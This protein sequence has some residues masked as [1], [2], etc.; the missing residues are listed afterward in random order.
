MKS[1][2]RLPVLLKLFER[3]NGRCCYCERFVVLSADYKIQQRSDAATIE[4]LRR[5]ADG[6]TNQPHNLSLAC[7]RCN[8]ERGSLSWILYATF[9]RGEFLEFMEAIKPQR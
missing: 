7:K 5:R 9:R 3:Q 4:H 8:Q 6:G 2:V 1:K